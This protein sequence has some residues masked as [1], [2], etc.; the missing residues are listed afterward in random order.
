MDLAVN[1]TERRKR[2]VTLLKSSTVPYSGTS[3]GRE[4]SVSRQVVVQDIALLRT[5]GYKILATARG[6]SARTYIK[7]YFAPIA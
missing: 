1:G 5:E 2:I 3:L 7:P 6:Y 4:L